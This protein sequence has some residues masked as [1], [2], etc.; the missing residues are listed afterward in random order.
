M[1]SHNFSRQKRPANGKPVVFITEV[2]HHTDPR[3][4]TPKAE[5]AREHEIE[6]LIRRGTWEIILEE[7]FLKGANMITWSFVVNIRYVETENPVSRFASY[8]MATDSEKEQLFHDSITA[9]QNSVRLWVAM[10]V[11]MGFKVRAEDIS[12]A[13]LQS[14]SELFREVYLKH[15]A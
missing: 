3:I 7:D 8:L 12:Q 14:A 10:A 9:R 6:N 5:K 11:I 2:L 4:C 13:Y 15:N 1:R